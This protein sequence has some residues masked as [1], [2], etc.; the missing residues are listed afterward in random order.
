MTGKNFLKQQLQ[1][2]KVDMP[3]LSGALKES[4]A[5]SIEL[6]TF[7]KHP[8][9]TNG[10]P[11]EET[12]TGRKK[13]GNADKGIVSIVVEPEKQSMTRKN[14]MKQQLQTGN[15]NMS[16]ESG[17]LK[18]SGAVRIVHASIHERPRKTRGSLTK[19]KKN[20]KKRERIADKVAFDKGEEPKKNRVPQD[21][22]QQEIREMTSKNPL[23]Q[24]LHTGNVNSPSMSGALK[25]SGAVRIVHASVHEPPKKTR[26]SLTKEKERVKKRERIADKVAFDKGEE[27]KK[28]RVPQDNLQQEIRE[29]TSKNPLKQQLHTGNV[30]S[31]SMSGALKKSGAVRIVHAS[32][33]EP[34]K[35]T[36]GSL[37]KEKKRVEKRERIA[38]KV[39]F[40]KG[41]FEEPEKNRLPQDNVQQ[42][43][44][45][46]K[47]KNPLKQ[48]L[49]TGNVNNPSVSGALK[50]SGAVDFVLVTI[51]EQPE[52]ACGSPSEERGSG[53]MKQG[54][55]SQAATNTPGEEVEETRL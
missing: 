50:K 28:N 30:N 22:L 13:E 53:E 32:V 10:S 40:D 41:E 18:K 24:Q 8:E 29:M 51:H 45:E 44:R 17:A 31:P 21:N 35:K 38:D 2:G 33:H 20:V 48:Q 55:V 46:M 39:A 6:T 23:K 19:E 4:G 5:V 15:V 49:Q 34:P 9:E 52:E 54:D 12:E 26:G 36:R 7:P 43:M 37:T 42:E 47:S 16:L 3:S 27:P 14:E 25:K 11:S 1:T